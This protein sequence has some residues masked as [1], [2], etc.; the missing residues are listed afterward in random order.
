MIALDERP[1]DNLPD[2][3]MA[4]VAMLTT[5]VE[6]GRLLGAAPLDALG[7]LLKPREEDDD[8]EE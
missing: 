5:V 2:R 1:P 3:V 7:Q 6:F 4:R 8:A